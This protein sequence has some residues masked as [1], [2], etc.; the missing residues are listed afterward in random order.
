MEF[1]NIC[2]TSKLDDKFIPKLEECIN[3]EGI[4]SHLIATKIYNYLKNYKLVQ[5]MDVK[6]CNIDFNQLIDLTSILP[7]LLKLVK[8]VQ[9]LDYAE[10]ELVYYTIVDILPFESSGDGHCCNFNYKSMFNHERMAEVAYET[11]KTHQSRFKEK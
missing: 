10:F 4:D 9:E 3:F 5:Q 8:I 2:D 7:E 11:M 1:F 6:D